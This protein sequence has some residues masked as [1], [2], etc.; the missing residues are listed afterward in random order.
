M[1]NRHL[2][3]LIKA[4]CRFRSSS[5]Y[6]VLQRQLERDAMWP[7]LHGQDLADDGSSSQA[8]LNPAYEPEQPAGRPG[9]RPGTASRGGVQPEGSGHR[10][11]P[12]ESRKDDQDPQ[13]TRCWR[14]CSEGTFPPV[15]AP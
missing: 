6:R 12:A 15:A 4:L 7:P 1:Q 2:W 3:L 5:R 13:E 11:S 8:Y 9:R 14:R 10:L